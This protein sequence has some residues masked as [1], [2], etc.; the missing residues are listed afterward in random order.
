MRLEAMSLTRFPNC[1]ATKVSS[2]FS[3]V[4]TNHRQLVFL[5]LRLD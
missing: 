3:V 4:I 5:L 1:T 2:V